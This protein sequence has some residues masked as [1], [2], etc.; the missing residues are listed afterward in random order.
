MIK[1]INMTI[2]MLVQ[3]TSSTPIFS[4]MGRASNSIM[5]LKLSPSDTMC[6][7]VCTVQRSTETRR[8]R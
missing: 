8:G 5:M 3:S 6:L 1:M 2:A 7:L 4:A